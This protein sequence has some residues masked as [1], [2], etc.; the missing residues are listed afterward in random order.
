MERMLSVRCW[1]TRKFD[2]CCAMERMQVMETEYFM[3]VRIIYKKGLVS[4][5]L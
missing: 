2:E 3:S 4:V 1:Q 5:R